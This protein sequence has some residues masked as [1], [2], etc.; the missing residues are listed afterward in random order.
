MA[1]NKEASEAFEV[2]D[3]KMD[4]LK[5]QL[6]KFEAFE[7]HVDRAIANRLYDL[8]VVAY[9]TLLL[10]VIMFFFL[11]GFVLKQVGL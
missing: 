7:Q 1:L 11:V 6:Q 3:A 10:V 2:L 5:E 8:R 4:G 9:L